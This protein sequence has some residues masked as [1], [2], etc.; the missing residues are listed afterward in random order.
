MSDLRA[1]KSAAVV[2]ACTCCGGRPPGGSGHDASTSASRHASG[3]LRCSAFRVYDT[4]VR[5]KGVPVRMLC[6]EGSGDS[7]HVVNWWLTGRM[8]YRREA[9]AVWPS[10]PHVNMNMCGLL[11]TIV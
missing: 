4:V 8:S 7:P 10:D 9:F 11:F 3:L 2:R 5:L 6:C 1:L